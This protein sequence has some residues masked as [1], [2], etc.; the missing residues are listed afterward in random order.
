M[1]SGAGQ[2]GQLKALIETKKSIEFQTQMAKEQ[3]DAQIAAIKNSKMK[4]A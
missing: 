1:G 3:S 2:N 4:H